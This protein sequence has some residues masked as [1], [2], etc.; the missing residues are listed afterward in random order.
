MNKPAPKE[1]SMDEILSSIRQI[2]ADDDASPAP[3]RAPELA[4]LQS[5]APSP[6]P[7]P[8][9]APLA[10]ENE[11]EPDALE[12]LALSSAQIVQDQPERLSPPIFGGFGAQGRPSEQPQ[13]ES[14]P[15][16]F[17]AADLVDPEDV[18]FEE[19]VAPIPPQF[20]APM[21]ERTAPPA[22]SSFDP[23]PRIPRAPMT[24][25][26]AAPLPDANLTRDMAEKLIQPATDMAVKHAF[27]RL[28]GLAMATPG[29]TIEALVREMLRP[30]LKEWLDENL[31]A[32]VERMVEREIARISR[33]DY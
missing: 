28:N 12:P 6:V 19:E 33:G 7:R 4:T 17:S 9:P 11:D 22:Q 31:P 27:S 26:E 13:M 29:V 1:P 10:N 3:R 20:N 16:A 21:S 30:M 18:S 8:M 32:I 5:I 23:P 2:I 25:A 14:R 24:V 15:P